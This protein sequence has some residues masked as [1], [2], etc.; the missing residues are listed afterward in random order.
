MLHNWQQIT[1]KRV[2]FNLLKKKNTNTFQEFE[3][4]LQMNLSSEQ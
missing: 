2:G 4:L 1:S 3:L